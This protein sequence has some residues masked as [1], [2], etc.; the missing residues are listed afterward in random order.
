MGERGV[1]GSGGK[2]RVIE[3]TWKLEF[4]RATA[5]V[6]QRNAPVPFE[7]A[8]QSGSIARKGYTPGKTRHAWTGRAHHESSATHEA[9]MPCRT[10]YT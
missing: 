4:L 6:E 8:G 10:R 2:L 1:S 9:H 3:R 7:T 5:S